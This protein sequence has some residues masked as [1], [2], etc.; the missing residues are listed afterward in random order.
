MALDSSLGHAKL[1]I[2]LP[3]NK[4]QSAESEISGR[5]EKR[6]AKPEHDAR[7]MMANQHLLNDYLLER[8]QLCCFLFSFFW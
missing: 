1:L 3:S 8:K 7:A 2:P 4:P 6:E 5:P